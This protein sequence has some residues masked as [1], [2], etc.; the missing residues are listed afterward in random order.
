MLFLGKKCPKC[1]CRNINTIKPSIVKR[2]FEALDW[3]T[4]FRGKSKNLNVCR[5]CSFSWEDR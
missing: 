2:T 4:I 1:D 3:T 5:E